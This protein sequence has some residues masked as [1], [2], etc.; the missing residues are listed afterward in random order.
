MN[1]DQMLVKK[2]NLLKAKDELLKTRHQNPDFYDMLFNLETELSSFKSTLFI[3]MLR[4]TYL[5]SNKTTNPEF[6][7]WKQNFK[8]EFLIEAHLGYGIKDILANIARLYPNSNINPIYYVRALRTQGYFTY[9]DIYD[10]NSRVIL[11]PKAEAYLN[12][13]VYLSQKR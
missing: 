7:I 13:E 4:N 12:N 5:S 2:Y 3:A 8:Q 10:E 9:A 1:Y 11:T 6:K